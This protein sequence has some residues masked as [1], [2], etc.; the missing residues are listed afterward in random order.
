V[1]LFYGNGVGTFDA[2]PET[3]N[4]GGGPNELVAAD[5]DKDATLDL[6]G[7]NYG[8][9]A[10]G[11]M[12]GGYIPPPAV[13]IGDATVTEG[14]TGPVNAVFE[15][16]LSRASDET[17]TV[18]YVAADGLAVAGK[19]FDL[20][21]GTLTFAPGETSKNITVAVRGDVIDEYD[22]GFAVNLSNATGAA[23]GDASGAGTIVDNDA[24]PSITITD[25][26]KKEGRRGT[27][28]FA[29]TVSLSAASEKDIFVDFATANG[30][31]TAGQDYLARSGTLVF[32]AGQ[33]SQL[34]TIS[35]NGDRT[36]EAS[37]T[38][39]VNLSGANGGTIVD[40]HGLGTIQDDDTHGKSKK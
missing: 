15:V 33:T 37:E 4:A 7:A 27:T 11:V 40:A 28:A 5:F 22:E 36:R 19:D 17:V 18:Q 13:S 23:L 35:V 12:L 16:T 29:F 1:N 32:A 39:F 6:A 10:V 8:W 26:A 3:V 21:P 9:N 31:A 20:V 24:A 2:T 25:V 38:F 34:L 14:D 30:T